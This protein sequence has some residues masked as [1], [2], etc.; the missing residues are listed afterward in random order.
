M[1]KSIHFLAIIFKIMTLFR[2]KIKLIYV[3]SVEHFYFW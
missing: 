1:F 3:S 2:E